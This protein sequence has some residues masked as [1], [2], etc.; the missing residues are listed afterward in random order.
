MSTA[1]GGLIQAAT[2][3]GVSS[4]IISF[5]SWRPNLGSANAT[6]QS[7]EMLQGNCDPVDWESTLRPRSISD[8]RAAVIHSAEARPDAVHV[9]DPA[10][11]DQGRELADRSGAAL[12]Y[13]VHVDYFATDRLRRLDAPSKAA[14]QQGLATSHADVVTVPSPAVYDSLAKRLG[15][16]DQ[17]IRLAPFG[18]NDSQAA[19]RSREGTS[20]THG[21]IVCMGRFGDVKGTDLIGNTLACLDAA[22]VDARVQLIGGL[23]ENPKSERRWL[24]QMRDKGASF[25]FLGWLGED[26][27]NQALTEAEIVFCPS[28]LETFSF[29]TLEG[30]LFGKPVVASLNGGSE[31]LL[32]HDDSGYLVN[33]SSGS[34]FADAL[35][36]LLENKSE[37]EALRR[38]AGRDALAHWCWDERIQAFIDAYSLATRTVRR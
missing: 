7:G 31:F 24:N 14:T 10:F 35:T 38:R 22:K 34:A 3:C 12:L 18:I 8:V 17:R 21:A 5:D 23:P 11:Y 32:R 25:E 28:R 37:A 16:D 6:R 30:M 13:T 1:V 19:R 4:R 36:K 27:R 33:R 2:L 20:P 9:H 15:S 26:D 29:A